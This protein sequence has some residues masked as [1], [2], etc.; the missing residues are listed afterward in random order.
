[1]SSN[2]LKRRGVL[3]LTAGLVLSATTAL[4]VNTA[5]A[6]AVLPGVNMEYVVV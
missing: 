3:G 2:T 4:A 5:P 1:M 6:Q